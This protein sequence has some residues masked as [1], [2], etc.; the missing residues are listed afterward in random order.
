MA[1]PVLE[2]PEI[3][4]PHQPYVPAETKIPELTVKALIL[5]SIFGMLF[6]TVSVYLGLKVGLTVSASIPVAVLA[7]TIL[8]KLGGST[9]LE[10]NIV[11]TIGSAGESI[12]AGVVFTIPAFIFLGFPLEISRVF[13]LALAGGCL[14]VLFMI[15]LRRDLIVREHGKLKYPEGTACAEV[16]IAGERGGSMAQNIFIGLGVGILYKILY[17]AIKI[18]RGTTEWKAKFFPG[19]SVAVEG[20]PELLGV[21]YII[22]FRTASEMFAGGLLSWI[23]IIPF[24]HFFGQH[25]P[26]A[27]YPGIVPI[28][29]MGSYDI[30]NAYVNYIGAG[31]VAAGGI[32][33][34]IKALPII[35]SSFKASFAE[36]TRSRSGEQI[37]K[38]RVNQDLSMTVVVIGSLFMILVIW[39]ILQFRI[40]P[41]YVAG[42]LVASILVV[43]LGFFFV[44]VSSRLVGLLGSSSNPISGMTIASLIAT[45][46][47]FLAVGWTGHTFMAVALSIGAVV[48]VAA[49]NAGATSQD[50]KTGYIVGSTPKNQQ[51]A[52]IVGVLAS[53]AIVGYS[54][55]WINQKYTKE[56]PVSIPSF[57]VNEHTVDRNRMIDYK[58]SQYILYT[59]IGDAKIP[60]GD[61]FVDPA[62]GQIKFQ[63]QYGIGS[64]RLPAPKANI[65]ASLIKGLLDQ[66]LPWALVL[67]GVS[68]AIIAELCGIQV[69]SFAVGVYL[70]VSTSAPIFVGGLVRHL[71]Q[72]KTGMNEA[73]IDSGRGTLYSSGLIAGG[74]L[75]GLALAAITGFDIEHMVAIGPKISAWFA[76]NNVIG[77]AIFG[78]LAYSVFTFGKK[79]L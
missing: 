3:A 32:I 56:V 67:L 37:E 54:M 19:A 50:L 21:G 75:A 42:N 66:K 23:V 47:V 63:R 5:G 24:V 14:G 13:F 71:I 70:P 57:N 59:S 6:G 10:N 11:Q 17:E 27:L 12:G 28:K 64:E 44:T 15:P 49:A 62:D 7:I 39:A 68:I 31:A 65:M 38:S 2:E 79:K 22:G 20:S 40:N 77:L 72:K 43:V 35:I 4:A 55:T 46:L 36:M 53:V 1:T 26:E 48:C 78:F 58:G 30:R 33:S 51:I 74:A 45:C 18:W 61:Y 73:E 16:L 29:D 25:I 9:I 60:D 34:L 41:E 76:N 52:L 8:K 69:L